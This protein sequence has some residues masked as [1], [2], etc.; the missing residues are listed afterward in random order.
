MRLLFLLTI[1]TL[2]S[3]GSLPQVS[4]TIK[5]GSYYRVVMSGYGSQHNGYK[6][7]IIKTDSGN[8]LVIRWVPS[9]SY[10][11]APTNRI[12]SLQ[13]VKDTTLK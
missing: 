1:I 10:E 4:V 3:A 13:V 5:I 12:D 11:G 7:S 9:G 6:D 8:T 2:L